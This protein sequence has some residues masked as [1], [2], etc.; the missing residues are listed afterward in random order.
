MSLCN[1]EKI[2]YS[3]Q[4]RCLCYFQ[5]GST[6]ESPTDEAPPN[7]RLVGSVKDDKERMFK[8]AIIY[9]AAE[10]ES[11]ARQDIKDFAIQV[12]S[13]LNIVHCMSILLVT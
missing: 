2:F 3:L 13:I 5:V 9:Y 12:V 6:L 8:G 4:T 7:E 11:K 1:V 10:M